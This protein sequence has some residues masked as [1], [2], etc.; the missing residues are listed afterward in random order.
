MT[1]NLGDGSFSD[2]FLGLHLYYKHCPSWGVVMYLSSASLTGGGGG[3]PWA[4]VGEYRDF[5]GTL[6]QISALV[7][8][9]MW[10]FLNALRTLGESVGTSLLCN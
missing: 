4:E 9:E 2:D 6:Q 1:S 8:G 7:V 3:G 10:G 5:I